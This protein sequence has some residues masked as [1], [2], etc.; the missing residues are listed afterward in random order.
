MNV[1]VAAFASVW[2]AVALYVGW[3][4]QNQR[5]LAARLH[6]LSATGEARHREKLPSAKAA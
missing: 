6:E 4:G 3:I 5:R 2:V 1:L